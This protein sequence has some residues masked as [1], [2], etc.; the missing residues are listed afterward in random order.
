LF[1]KEEKGRTSQFTGQV[2][3]RATHLPVTSALPAAARTNIGAEISA[4]HRSLPPLGSAQLGITD[5]CSGILLEPIIMISNFNNLIF[6]QNI[7][8]ENKVIKLFGSST[9]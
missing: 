9:D 8:L 7:L 4:L 1:E 6:Q 5:A 3:H 2:F